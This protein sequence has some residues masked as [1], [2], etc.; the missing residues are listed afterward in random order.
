MP[1]PH[2]EAGDDLGEIQVRPVG[3]A[4]PGRVAPVQRHRQRS[5]GGALSQ[6]PSKMSISGGHEPSFGISQK[7]GHVP[8]TK[9][10]LQAS[11]DVAAVPM[12]TG[13][14]DAC[15]IADE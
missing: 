3:A 1:R 12:E 9:V 13:S 6:K 14:F 8:A 11:F 10:H 4:C 2:I 15:N 7:A 5:A